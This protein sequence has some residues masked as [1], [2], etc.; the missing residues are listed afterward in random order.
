VLSFDVEPLPESWSADLGVQICAAKPQKLVWWFD[1]SRAWSAHLRRKSGGADL[2][3]CAPNIENLLPNGSM[4]HVSAEKRK[5]ETKDTS[6]PLVHR[7]HVVA[8]PACLLSVVF[9]ARRGDVEVGG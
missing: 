6:P 4:T 5:T 3:S 2:R 1:V 7:L 8:P 9:V